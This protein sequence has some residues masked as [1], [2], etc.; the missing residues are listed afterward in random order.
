MKISASNL[1]YI[2][3]CASLALGAPT[4]KRQSGTTYDGGSTANDVD[5]GGTRIHSADEIG[6]C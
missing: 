6:S 2:L 3:Y 5:S 4:P 1:A